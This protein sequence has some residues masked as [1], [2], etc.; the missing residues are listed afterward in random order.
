MDIA[1]DDPDIRPALAN[2]GGDFEGIH[3]AG[4]GCRKTDHLRIGGQHDFRIFCGCR[5]RVGAKT[6]VQ[7]HL[8]PEFF[9][10]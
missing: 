1:E 4:R 2:D 7:L 6:V 9:Q 5:R 10:P 3:E 8:M